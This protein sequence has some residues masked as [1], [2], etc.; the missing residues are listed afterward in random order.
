VPKRC[1]W[2]LWT[3]DGNVSV[4]CIVLIMVVPGWYM[5]CLGSGHVKTK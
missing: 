4:V 1:M 3:M 5:C 2:R